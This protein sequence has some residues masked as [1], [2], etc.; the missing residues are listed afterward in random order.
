MQEQPWWLG[1]LGHLVG[2][3]RTC[4]GHRLPLGASPSCW[5]LSDDW[6]DVAAGGGRGKGGP[7]LGP[8]Q[9]RMADLGRLA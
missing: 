6:M 5:R 8:E 7:K 3:S 2:I 4:G 9:A 1:G